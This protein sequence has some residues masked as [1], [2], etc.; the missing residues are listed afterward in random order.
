MK[1]RWS[2]LFILLVM[3]LTA[4]CKNTPAAEGNKGAGGI[5]GGCES[6]K[7]KAILWIDY[8]KDK[9]PLPKSTRIK[10][11]KVY[12]HVYADGTFKILSFCKKQ[13]V[14]VKDYILKRA[15]IYTIRKEIF[16]GNYL[17]PGDQYLQLRY[18]PG[19]IK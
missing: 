9:L 1:T 5:V 10:T 17:E 4:A 7:A 6:E 2:Y 16:E 13:P 3:L 19:W 12:A 11:V 15:E 14:R 8:N 18:I